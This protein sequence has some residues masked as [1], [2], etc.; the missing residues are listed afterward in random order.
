M[1]GA[2][3][4]TDGD[5]FYAALVAKLDAA[6]EE[7]GARLLA[8]LALLLAA[9]VGDQTRLLELLERAAAPESDAR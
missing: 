8:R 9:E 1:S 7:G 5:A 6:G 4:F 2:L 3:G